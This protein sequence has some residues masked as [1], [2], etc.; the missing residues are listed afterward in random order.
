MSDQIP[1]NQDLRRLSAGDRDALDRLME[2]HYGEFKRIAHQ[3]FSREG[4]R[5]TLQTTAVVHEAFLRLAKRKS[6][7]VKDLRALESVF[8]QMVTRVLADHAKG[9]L[10]EKRGSGVQT[11][12]LFESIGTSAPEFEN[13]LAVAEALH[14]F[15]EID[16]RASECV[17]LMTVSQWTHQKIADW[18]GISTKTVSRD[19]AAARAWL[20]RELGGNNDRG[21]GQG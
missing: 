18:L 15:S 8:A 1:K 20:R 19:I 11:V 13:S 4:R 17:R 7:H 2:L 14:R 10:A 16:F 12:E 3:K 5:I 9:R 6:I 21:L